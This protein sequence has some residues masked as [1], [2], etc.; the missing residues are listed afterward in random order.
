MEFDLNHFLLANFLQKKQEAGSG[1]I[2][3]D[4]KSTLSPT[5]VADF[6]SRDLSALLKMSV[7]FHTFKEFPTL[8]C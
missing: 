1:F 7:N 5:E 4:F 2:L 6:K 8:G 3:L